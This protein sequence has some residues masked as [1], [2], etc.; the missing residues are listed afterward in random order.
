MN[1]RTGSFLY[2]FQPNNSIYAYVPSARH[3][4]TAVLV[5][6]KIY[7][8]G[9]SGATTPVID[10][11]FYLDVSNTFDIKLLP[12]TDLSYKVSSARITGASCVNEIKNDSIFFIGGG[13]PVQ[14]FDLA[15]QSWSNPLISGNEPLNITG[16]N[17][18]VSKDAIYIFGGNTLNNLY[19]L[20][21][22]TLTWT[23]ST[24]TN[25]PTARFRYSVTLLPNGDALYIGGMTPDRTLL[26][27]ADI[28][29]YN[30]NSDSWRTIT[31]SGQVPATRAGH[32]ATFISKYDQIL[33]I[34]GFQVAGIVAL[35]AT[36]F[37]WSVPAVS[38]SG[39][40]ILPGLFWHTSTLIGDYI[41]VAFGEYVDN[42]PSSNTY[43]LDISQKNNYMWTSSYTP[44]N[45][46]SPSSTSSS[47]SP[48]SPSNPSPP[49][50][51]SSSSNSATSPSPTTTD[52]PSSS[53]NMI[54]IIVGGIAGGTIVSVLLV[55]AIFFGIRR[56]R[57]RSVKVDQP[58]YNKNQPPYNQP[59]YNNQVSTDKDTIVSEH[60]PSNVKLL[61]MGELISSAICQSPTTCIVPNIA[62]RFWELEIF[63]FIIDFDFSQRIPNLINCR[64]SGH[65]SVALVDVIK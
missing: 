57:R 20:N 24:A 47:T 33:I 34:D 39:S 14:K 11:F 2:V 45:A 41:F 6:N 64:N 21:T 27:I 43:L 56:I 50:N 10:N 38:N 60:S 36:K 53:S 48:S 19:I 58:P 49:S 44:T 1:E 37:V 3:G 13:G 22:S 9:G 35:D 54:V 52:S 7:F 61:Q 63:S 15:T 16:I 5:D 55:A 46:V 4:H 26:P 42:Q 29:T 62:F 8:Q 12:W 51:S 31:T 30:V 28:P 65:F 32:T 18:V 59:P 17:C 23:V 40:G 25:A